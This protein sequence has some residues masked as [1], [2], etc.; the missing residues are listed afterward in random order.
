MMRTLLSD[1]LSE[2]RDGFPLAAFA[3]SKNPITCSSSIKNGIAPSASAGYARP[4]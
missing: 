1:A 3:V 4:C 2:G